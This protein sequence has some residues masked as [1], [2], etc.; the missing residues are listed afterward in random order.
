MTD[1]RPHGLTLPE[2]NWMPVH[3]GESGAEVFRSSDGRRFAKRVPGSD[4]AALEAERDR[5]AWLGDAGLPVPRVLDWKLDGASGAILITSAIA[6]VPAD[7][8]EAPTLIPAWPSIAAAVRR[9]HDVDPIGCPFDAGV[10]WRF[11]LAESVVERGA[12]N[13]EFLPV[14]QQQTPPDQL[15][16]RLR[17]RRERLET[18]E[19]ADLVVTHG[20][21]TLANLL[22]DP[23]R[24]TVTGFIDLGRAGRA[25]RHA[26]LALLLE[27]ARE[28]WPDAAQTRAR[29][30]RIYGRALDPVRLR[31]YLHLD[32]LTWG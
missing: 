4:A 23:E 14:E 2:N 8:L 16:A 12:V 29:F 22:V 3:R 1:P 13:P 20:D 11:E 18:L 25:D 10:A 6:G 5:L 27:T 32:P 24:A 17:S 7:T 26:D 15:I 9:L 21:L 19:A 31:D 28:I 30:E